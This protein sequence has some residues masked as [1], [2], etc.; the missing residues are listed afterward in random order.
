MREIE[1]RGQRKDTGEWVYGYLM[2]MHQKD[3]LFIG[4]WRS[5]GGEATIKDELFSGYHEVDPETVGQFTG[6]H[7]KN[8]KKI[9]E[10]DIVKRGDWIGVVKNG[11]YTLDGSGPCPSVQGIGFYIECQQYTHNIF[12]GAELSNWEVIGTIHSNPEL[13]EESQ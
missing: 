7:D 1:F 2:Q 3:R 8:K 13:L 5:I 4:Q 12:S 11:L 10:G 9:F 6:L